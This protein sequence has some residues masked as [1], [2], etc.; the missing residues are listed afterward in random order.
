[1]NN[2]VEKTKQANE[3]FD[4]YNTVVK[5]HTFKIGAN[6]LVCEEVKDGHIKNNGSEV[7]ASFDELMARMQDGVE[8]ITEVVK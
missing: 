1:M 8:V 4:G 5:I 3:F 6:E 7:A 2:I